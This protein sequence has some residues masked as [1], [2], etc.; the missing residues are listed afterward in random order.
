MI[1]RIWLIGLAVMIGA[2]VGCSAAPAAV[3]DEAPTEEPTDPPTEQAAPIDEPTE[4]A[5]SEAT[6]TTEPTEPPAPT[7]EPH[8]IQTRT[9]AHGVEQVYVP[10]GCFMMGSDPEVDD[11]AGSFP[12]EQPAHE[13]CLTEGYWI[14][15]Y[16]ATNASWQAFV[17]AGGY[18]T[19]EFW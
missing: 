19:P 6:A 13:T 1:R 10:A 4:V 12:A 14:D 5:V 18:I 3:P 2:L 15:K 8:E 17:E 7:M 16:E 9:D 11:E